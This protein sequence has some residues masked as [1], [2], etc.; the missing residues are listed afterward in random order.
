MND[1]DA[2]DEFTE[3]SVL[4]GVILTKAETKKGL[5]GERKN[6]ATLRR[7]CHAIGVETMECFG[8]LLL[9]CFVI[10]VSFIVCMLNLLCL[11]LV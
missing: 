10:S 1:I 6:F 7:A 8:Y 3:A 4:S 9:G 2:L 5:E 11:R